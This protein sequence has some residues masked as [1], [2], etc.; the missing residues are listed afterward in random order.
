MHSLE[1][2]LKWSL[3]VVVFLT[4]V[5]VASHHSRHV[6]AGGGSESSTLRHILEVQEQRVTKDK[7]L[8]NALSQGSRTAKAA[9][10]ALGRIGDTSALDEIARLLNRKDKELKSTAAFSLGIMGGDTALKILV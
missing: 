1:A 7:I 5:A 3:A 2:F 4:A 10:L 6:A 8:I 9:L